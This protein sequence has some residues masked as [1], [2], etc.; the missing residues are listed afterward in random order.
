MTA[1]TETVHDGEFLLSEADFTLSRDEITIVSGQNLV[2]GTVLGK[3]TTGGKYKIY[4]NGDGDGSQVAAGVLLNAV[5]ATDGD[6][7]GVIINDDAEVKGALL[8]WGTN[9][10]TGITAGTADLLA[11][12]IKVRT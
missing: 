11:L 5:D 6:K 3:I 12:H 10:A 1:F 4:A 9:D 2:A 8:N 7:K